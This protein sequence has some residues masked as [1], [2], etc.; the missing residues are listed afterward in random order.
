MVEEVEE[1]REEPIVEEE[2]GGLCSSWTACCVRRRNSFVDG[3]SQSWSDETDLVV[4][5]WEKQQCRWEWVEEREWFLG[6]G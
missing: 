5:N 4:M 6:Q 3:E 2:T 1:A